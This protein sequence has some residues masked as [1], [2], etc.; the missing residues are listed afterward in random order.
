MVV[1]LS[2]NYL[3]NNFVFNF[4]KITK[5]E[6][7]IIILILLFAFMYESEKFVSVSLRSVFVAFSTNSIGGYSTARR[8]NEPSKI[9]SE[10]SLPSKS[11]EEILLEEKIKFEKKL[12]EI[13]KRLKKLAE[14]E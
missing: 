14:R 1:K 3:I 6:K 2:V 11:E 13:E 12:E 8:Y 9:D 10:E 4:L 7:L 5:M